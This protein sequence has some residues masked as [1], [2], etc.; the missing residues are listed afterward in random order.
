MV[1]A[2]IACWAFSLRGLPR[3]EIAVANVERRQVRRPRRPNG[4]VDLRELAREHRDAD[5][6]G[7]NVVDHERQDVPLGRQS[8]DLDAID[9]ATGQIERRGHEHAHPR[10]RGHFRLRVV[11]DVHDR[12]R[13]LARRQDVQVRQAGIRA[14]DAPQRLMPALEVAER[15]REG[16]GIERAFEHGDERHVI[17]RCLW[18]QLVKNP[19]APLRVREIVPIAIG[20]PWDMPGR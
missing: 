10:A 17:R 14:V 18:I 19:E 5:A 6:V 8:H 9:R 16:A 4:A 15:D 20:Q 2:R 11:R 13:R 12:H 1:A 3:R 7:R